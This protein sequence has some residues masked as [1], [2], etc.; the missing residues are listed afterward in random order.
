MS[1]DLGTWQR[2]L[3]TAAAILSSANNALQLSDRF[4]AARQSKW[5]FRVAVGIAFIAV[6]VGSWYARD[7]TL[8]RKIAPPAALTPTPKPPQVSQAASNAGEPRV[9]KPQ[10]TTR[11]PKPAAGISADPACKDKLRIHITG[12]EVTG[13]IGS[14]IK[15]DNADVCIETNNA[16]ITGGTDGINLDHTPSP[17]FD[18]LSTLSPGKLSP[19]ELPLNDERRK[20]GAELLEKYLAS[21]PNAT[22]DQVVSEI[23]NELVS[24][25]VNAHI[26]WED[27][28]PRK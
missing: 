8:A 23:N 27:P 20:E 25:G 9:P 6:A 10:T 5:F 22:H 14:G 13:R 24:L 11:R 7:W 19:G 3:T 21:H 2:T 26:T 28:T 16:K 15:A 4:K 1:F 12:G 17:Y 18:A